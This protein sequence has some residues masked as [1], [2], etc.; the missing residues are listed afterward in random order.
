MQVS[1]LTCEITNIFISKYNKQRWSKDRRKK[2][3]ILSDDVNLLGKAIVVTLMPDEREVEHKIVHDGHVLAEKGDFEIDLD[4]VEAD[5][6][7]FG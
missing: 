2:E 6:V 5:E 3:Y 1:F 7:V 4:K